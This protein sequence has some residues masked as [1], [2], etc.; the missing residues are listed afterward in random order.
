MA[1]AISVAVRSKFTTGHNHSGSAIREKSGG[2]QVRN[3]QI[4]AL[5][6]ERT[7]LDRNQ[8]RGLRGISPNVIRGA[9]DSSSAGYTSEA[10]DWSAANIGRELHS[11]DQ[12][13]VD[14][15]ACHA[16]NCR[17]KQCSKIFCFQSGCLKRAAK[18]LLS[19][20]LSAPDPDIVS[21]APGFYI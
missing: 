10:K 11:I 6:R 17:E 19:Q 18:G 1:V 7:E 3:R 5:Q 21:L 12:E 14:R 4:F 13:G 9:R 16:G 15:G 20:L 2:D 8:R